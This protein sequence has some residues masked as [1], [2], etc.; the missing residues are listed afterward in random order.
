VKRLV[1]VV[2]LVILLAG[3][4]LFGLSYTSISVADTSVQDNEGKL[5]ATAN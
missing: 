4:V 3:L 2:T 5:D 1:I